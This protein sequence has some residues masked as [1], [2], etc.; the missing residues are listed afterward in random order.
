MSSDNKQ[1][2]QVFT[3]PTRNLARDISNFFKNWTRPEEVSA[4]LI[5]QELRKYLNEHSFLQL[6]NLFIKIDSHEG[7]YIG[8]VSCSFLKRPL[9][10]EILNV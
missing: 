2:I 3:G 7:G 9:F 5:E 8:N 10:F 6:E 1:H 4:E